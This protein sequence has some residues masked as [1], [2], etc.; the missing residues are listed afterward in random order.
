MRS[1]ICMLALC[2]GLVAVAGQLPVDD[3]ILALRNKADYLEELKNTLLEN[4]CAITVDGNTVGLVA[5]AIRSQALIMGITRTNPGNYYAYHMAPKPQFLQNVVGAA[6][7][8]IVVATFL[9]REGEN[10]PAGFQVKV[11]EPFKVTGA[12]N[13]WLYNQ[14]Y[15][16]LAV[17]KAQET[18][19]GEATTQSGA[20]VK[21]VCNP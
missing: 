8:K 18:L 19:S 11:A 5:G 13:L 15:L 20:S 9:Y 7:A 4:R 10:K 16:N 1:F 17:P 6:D 14:T 12:E 21:V 2:A 3:E